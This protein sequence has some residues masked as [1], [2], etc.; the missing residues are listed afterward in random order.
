MN[1]R[2][3]ALAALL[4]VPACAAAPART[5]PAAVDTA[6]DEQELAEAT[7]AI[8]DARSE[9]VVPRAESQ[10]QPVCR[11]SEIICTASERICAIADRHRGEALY[12]QKC[13]D[14]EGSC[15]EA[16]GDCERCQ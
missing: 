7:K 10:C 15:T 5:A 12:A 6:A 2:G 4:A 13:K 8:Q 11:L 3:L 9:L 16:R 1:H 14:A